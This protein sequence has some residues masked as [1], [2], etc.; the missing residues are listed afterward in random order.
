M[1]YLTE[2]ENKYFE[3]DG[4]CNEKGQDLNT[5]L[6]EYNP[7]IY[8]NSSNTV[9]TAIFSFSDKN[10][11]YKIL[12]IKRK[13]HPSIGTWALP[14]G[15]VDYGEDVFDA[16]KRELFEET[17]IKGL[18]PVQIRTYGNGKRDPRTHII[19][20]LYAALVSE[21]SISPIA[22]DDAG[23]AAFF[24]IEL[25][26]A[27]DDNIRLNLFYKEKDLS[28]SAILKMTVFDKGIVPV[29]EY[30]IIRSEG[31]ALDHAILITD[32]YDYIMNV[33]RIKNER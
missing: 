1:T 23:D 3:G 33:Q 13:N 11:K 6:E 16:A 21:N 27:G 15:F 19:T 9:D 24:D 30:E 25:N 5:F 12:L 8:K 26:N 22:G 10:N 17:N 2:E 29:K 18:Y 31:I 28:L 7:W 4:S 20:T 14:G 32:A